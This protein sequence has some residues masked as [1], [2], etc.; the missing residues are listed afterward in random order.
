[1]VLL[2]HY[3]EPVYGNKVYLRILCCSHYNHAVHI[4]HCRSDKAVLPIIYLGYYR[5][6]VFSLL[7]FYKITYYQALTLLSENA[8]ALGSYYLLNSISPPLSHLSFA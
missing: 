1:M 3:E 5:I 6:A 8:S 2:C 4:R 7:Y